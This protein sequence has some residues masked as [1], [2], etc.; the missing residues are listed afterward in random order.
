MGCGAVSGQKYEADVA[1]NTIEDAP[2]PRSAASISSTDVIRQDVVKS[3][4]AGRWG[5]NPTSVVEQHTD[6]YR[7]GCV[8]GIE[9]IED[10]EDEAD[11]IARNE[12]N[13]LRKYAAQGYQGKTSGSRKIF[14][15]SNGPLSSEPLFHDY[16]QQQQQHPNSANNDFET[17]LLNHTSTVGSLKLQHTSPNK[18][19][20]KNCWAS[21]S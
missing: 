2:K 10:L 14:A 11:D 13:P 15:S 1:L 17:L 7:V 20:L 6:K 12:Q 16:M 3:N 18:K 4:D 21:D 19:S 8:A 9:V 5:E